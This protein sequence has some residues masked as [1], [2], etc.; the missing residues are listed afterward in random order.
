MK[1]RDVIRILDA[2]VL[3]DG[4]LDTEVKTG[5]RKRHDERCVGFC[6]RSGDASYRPV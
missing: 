3:V 5:L 4:N 6:E 2:E 1:V